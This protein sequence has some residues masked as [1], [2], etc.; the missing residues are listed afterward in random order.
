VPN[1][2]Y[3]AKWN[4][5]DWSGALGTGI[6]SGAALAV[7]SAGNLYAGGYFV[8]M[9]GDKAPCIAEW[10][11]TDWSALRTG[12]DGVSAL[13]VD[14]AGNLYAGG[15][16]TSTNG[17]T[18]TSY[19]AKWNGTDWSALSTEINGDV[20]ALAVDSAGNLYVG[21]DFTNAGGVA[22]TSH[23]AK[24]NGTAWSALSTGINGYGYG[25]LRALAFDGSGNLYAGGSFTSAGGVTNTSYIAKWNGT[26]W[27]ALGTGTNSTVR[28]LAVDSSGNL[29]AGGYFTS[30][31]GVNANRIAMW[32]S[33]TQATA[34][35]A[36]A[37]TALKVLAGISVAAVNADMNGDKKIGLEEV[38][39]VLQ[40][41]AGLRP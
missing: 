12:I 36:D 37:I 34:G 21:G 33:D 7:D 20:S 14:S 24:W 23:I 15:S 19:I 17:V 29:Y 22:N 40:K 25:L 39:Y 28:A 38:V 6:N 4:G 5:T 8:N 32:K 31:G 26:A 18:I 41:V 1:T 3:I 10:N 13:A 27:S 30:A 9:C 2:K 16:F 35:L 11:G